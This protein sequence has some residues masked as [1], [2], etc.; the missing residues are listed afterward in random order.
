MLDV[1]KQLFENNVISE[2]IQAQKET[3]KQ[4]KETDKQINRV[5]KQIGELGNR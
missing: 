1:L 3:D 5:S 4:I 2:E